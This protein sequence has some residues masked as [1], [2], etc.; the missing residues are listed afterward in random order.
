MTKTKTSS[1][2]STEPKRWHR[3]ITLPPSNGRATGG[4]LCDAVQRPA[5]VPEFRSKEEIRNF[6]EEMKAKGKIRGPLFVQ[7]PDAARPAK[8]ERGGTVATVAGS[9]AGAAGVQCRWMDVTPKLAAEWLRNNFVNRPLS[10]DTVIAYARDMA[11][12]VWTRTH[13]GIAFNDAD[14][15]IDGQHRLH[16]VVRSGVTVPMMVTFGLPAKIEGA[17][18]TTMDAVDRGKPRSVAD[19]L[20][21]QHGMKQGSA[22]AMVVKSIAA[23]CSSERTRKLSVGQTLDIYGEFRAQVDK[24]IAERPR[25]HGLKSAGVLAGFAFALAVQP[26]LDAAWQALRD[27]TAKPGSAVARLH[28]F[29]T[30]D[31]AKLLMRSNDRALAELVLETLRLEVL[32]KPVAKLE[33]GE[34]GARQFRAA[35]PA[36]V[37]KIARMFRLG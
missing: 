11:N 30:G 34:E 6:V 1:K 13:Q 10:E 26:A 37:E 9:L 35:Q 3:A 24:V 4:L 12:K 20:R 36:R 32:G 17:Q 18:M 27:G 8:I 15:L 22:I 31:Q 7:S 28:A 2:K 33:L 29:L 21:I 23:L 19:Q 16:A 25:E 5:E 14:A